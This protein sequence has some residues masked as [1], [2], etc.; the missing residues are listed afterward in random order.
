MICTSV[1]IVVFEDR[2]K[3]FEPRYNSFIPIFKSFVHRCKWFVARSKY[4]KIG[5]N[6]LYLGP[7]IWIYV[8]LAFHNYPCCVTDDQTYMQDAECR[9]EYVM[10][11]TGYVYVGSVRRQH[12][13][14]W[15]FGQV[16]NIVIIYACFNFPKFT[17][18]HRTLWHFHNIFML[19]I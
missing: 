3:S 14:P 16:Q 17:I 1:Q 10:N 15:N 19:A 4:L 2:Y 18:C 7:N 9:E 6:D 11:Q 5:I 8:N 12:G 13:R